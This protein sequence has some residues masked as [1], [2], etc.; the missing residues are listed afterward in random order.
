M[1]E[2]GACQEIEEESRRQ[3]PMGKYPEGGAG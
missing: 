1:I 3:I 2:I